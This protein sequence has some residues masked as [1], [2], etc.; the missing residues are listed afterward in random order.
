MELNYKAC[1]ICG[2]EIG[3]DRLR[4][5]PDTK[6]CSR[7]ECGGGEVSPLMRVR[8]ERLNPEYF[9]EVCVNAFDELDEGGNLLK[10]YLMYAWELKKKGRTGK[11]MANFLR[12]QFSK[13]EIKEIQQTAESEFGYESNILYAVPHPYWWLCRYDELHKEEYKRGANNA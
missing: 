9:H 3:L 8:Q 2:D 13:K 10:A 12:K 1:E 7:V 5:Y 11:V 6:T 4:Q